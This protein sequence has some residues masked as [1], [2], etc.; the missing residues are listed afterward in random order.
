MNG[1]YFRRWITDIHSTAP[2]PVNQIDDQ[3]FYL[4]LGYMIVP[5]R[6]ELNARTSQ[7]YGEFGDATEY[8]GGVNWFI[9]GTHNY[10]F[11]VDVTQLRNTPANNTGVN[12]RVGT[13]G[14]MVRVQLQVA[15]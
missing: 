5:K 15:F 3:G 10:K 11:T 9:D 12:Y 14:T 2:I 7:I 13:E 6:V 1:E 4:E 8:A